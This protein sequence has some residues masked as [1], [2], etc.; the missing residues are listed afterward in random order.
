MAY[1]SKNSFTD[2]IK[3]VLKRESWLLIMRQPRRY[4]YAAYCR[5]DGVGGHFFSINY[6][7]SMS[8]SL[9][10]SSLV[11][12]HPVAIAATTSIKGIKERRNGNRGRKKKG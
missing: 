4:L 8:S 5:G 1:G 9:F 3:S 7:S 11:T 6:F 10:C 12:E 2:N